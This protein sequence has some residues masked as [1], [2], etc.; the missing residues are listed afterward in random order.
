P[1]N[2]F[3]IR[4]RGMS[5]EKYTEEE[6]RLTLPIVPKKVDE[7]D[8]QAP[9]DYI[10]SRSES[11]ERVIDADVNVANFVLEAL[12]YGWKHVNINSVRS[13]KDMADATLSAV[14]RR[15]R[16]LNMPH[17]HSSKSGD[18]GTILPIS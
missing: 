5:E 3:S 1:R 13:L 4:L 6:D 17:G 9:I 16:L 15:R 12:M 14:E 2:L 11:V 7:H 10:V 8:I 18:P